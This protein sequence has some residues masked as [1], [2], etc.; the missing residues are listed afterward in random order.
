MTKEECIYNYQ[1]EL[2]AFTKRRVPPCH[3]PFHNF[4]SKTKLEQFSRD[5]WGIIHDFLPEHLLN[6]LQTKWGTY[7]KTNKWGPLSGGGLMY[8]HSKNLNLLSEEVLFPPPPPPKDETKKRKGRNSR[9]QKKQEEKKK[10]VKKVINLEGLDKQSP[11]HEWNEL[12]E[13]AHRE[14]AP[15]FEKL[16]WVETGGDKKG[17]R[18]RVAGGSYLL[19]LDDCLP[20]SWH[21]DSPDPNSISVILPVTENCPMTDFAAKEHQPRHAMLAIMKKAGWERWPPGKDDIRDHLRHLTP[22]EA[23]DIIEDIRKLFVR[24]PN[25]RGQDYKVDERCNCIA[26]PG[27]VIF[28]HS[29]TCHRAKLH[30]ADMDPRCAFFFQMQFTPNDYGT[31]SAVEQIYMGPTTVGQSECVYNYLLECILS[32]ENMGQSRSLL[33]NL[34]WHHKK[35][36]VVQAKDS[37][38]DGQKWLLL[39][40]WYIVLRR[41]PEK[42]NFY[43]PNWEDI[44]TEW[45]FNYGSKNPCL[46]DRPGCLCS[47]NLHLSASVLS[48]YSRFM[49]ISGGSYSVHASPDCVSDFKK[50]LTSTT[51]KRKSTCISTSI[52]SSSSY[53]SSNESSKGN[54]S[55]SSTKNKKIKIR[56]ETSSFPSTP[57]T[58]DVP[59]TPPTPPT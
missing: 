19:Y 38:D 11:K 20:Q 15:L 52:S 56:H 43:L 50:L 9:K 22:E 8:E 4:P 45:E 17:W 5:G 18:Y 14:L 24:D 10:K 7:L 30:F 28:F 29:L 26:R 2:V 23:A 41:S 44:P 57:P 1:P 59:P 36:E 51:P 58:S 13:F 55:T 39:F 46:S 27:A 35:K 6:T 37:L 21:L 40:F 47:N 16:G 49:S 25:F 12:L 32:M 33:D 48:R 34:P 54:S 42:L 3:S 31:Y 53:T